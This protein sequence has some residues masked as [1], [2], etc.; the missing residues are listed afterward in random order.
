MPLI[1]IDCAE[2]NR[3]KKAELIRELT[4]TASQVLSIPEAAFML[5]FKEYA[6]DN[7]GSGGKLVADLLP[8]PPTE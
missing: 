8:K 4:K 1:T 6:P 2:L 5:I 3:E 7:I